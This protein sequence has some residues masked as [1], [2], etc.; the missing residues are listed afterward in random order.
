VV[1]A[2]DLLAGVAEPKSLGLQIRYRDVILVRD[3]AGS[4]VGHRQ[5]GNVGTDE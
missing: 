3:Q 4:V 5:M 2:A 1:W